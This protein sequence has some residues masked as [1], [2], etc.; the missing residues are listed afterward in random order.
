MVGSRHDKVMP[1][2]AWYF[3][4]FVFLRLCR[5][6]S[7]ALVGAICRDGDLFYRWH[8]ERQARLARLILDQPL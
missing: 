2:V 7:L 6:F 3:T 8:D 1:L 4:G 5:K